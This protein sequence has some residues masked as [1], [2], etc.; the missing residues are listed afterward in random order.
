M[1][2]WDDYA[3][4]YDSLFAA[5]P[6]YADAMRMM[7]ELMGE[8]GRK[9]VLDLGCGSGTLISRLA[10]L[11]P[12]AEIYGVDPSQAMVRRSA[13]RFAGLSNVH[14][15]AGTAV[16]IPLP[17]AHVHC[18][19]SNLALHHVPPG[20]RQ[21]CADE[22]ARVLKP[23][24]RLLYADMFLDVPGPADD[25]ERCRDIIVKMVGKSLYGL[26][27]GALE[28]AL[29][30]IGDIPSVVREEGE[31]FTTDAAWREHFAAA[32]LSRLEVLV[33]PPQDFGYRIIAGIRS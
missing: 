19:M 22:V 5:D 16:S 3:G 10:A 11:H 14:I 1:G 33:V 17:S 8:A 24:G 29:L 18:L 28:T 21:A 9:R 7:V 20:E 31:Y 23:G 30:H 4:D 25:L 6:M 26:Q 13:E 2:Y 32:G 15:S 12:E 27:H